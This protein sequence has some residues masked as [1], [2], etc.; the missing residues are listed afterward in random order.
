M[1]KYNV[2]IMAG[3]VVDKKEDITK[4]YINKNIDVI[5]R[6][7]FG[8]IKEDPIIE[9]LA[10]L[11]EAIDTSDIFDDEQLKKLELIINNIIL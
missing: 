6:R 10:I 2:I 1:I 11:I 5:N 8:I 7:K 3:G 4:L 9:Q